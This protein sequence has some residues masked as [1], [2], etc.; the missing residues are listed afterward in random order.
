MRNQPNRHRLVRQWLSLA[1][2]V[3]LGFVFLANTQRLGDWVRSLGYTATAAVG[4]LARDDTFTSAANHLYYINRPVLETKQSF[5]KH[6]SSQQEQT[7]VLGCYHGN[8]RG[9]Y[10]LRIASDS[11][12]AGVEQVTAAHEMLHAVYDRLS[13]HDK[14]KVDAW[15]LDYYHNGLTDQRIKDTIAV[16]KQSEPDAVVNEMHSV[17]GTEVADL[18]P[19]L[20]NYYQQYFVN[21]SQVTS[22][23]A[24]YQ[25]EF[26]DRQTQVA[27]DDVKLKALKAEIEANEAALTTQRSSLQAR[28][29]QMDQLKSSGQTA[30]YNSQVSSYNA[31]IDSYNRLADTT[32]QQIASYNQL[33]A[34]RNS[35]AVEQQHLSSELSGD[36]ISTYNNR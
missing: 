14:S 29:Q 1:I 12:L 17:F 27:A 28:A 23:A 8:Q 19:N 30:A 2:I 36:S 25:A 32:K 31:A 9:I 26:T 15:L 35:I 3:V 22:Y 4:N 20:T 10:I 13:S 5:R 18:P 16:Y 34:A 11:R 24:S 21:R 7:I 33:V 6:C